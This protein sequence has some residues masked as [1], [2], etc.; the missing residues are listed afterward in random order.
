MFSEVHCK[1]RT[2]ARCKLMEYIEGSL[3]MA[4]GRRQEL[5]LDTDKPRITL[6]VDLGC[7][8]G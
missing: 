3:Q 7:V 8:D 1:Q 4:I 2:L 6:H 5:L